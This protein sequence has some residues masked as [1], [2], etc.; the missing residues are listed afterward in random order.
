MTAAR[1]LLLAALSTSLGCATFNVQTEYDP[2]ANFAKYKVYDFVSSVPGQE[3]APA[4]R[5]P[6]VRNWVTSAI[7]RELAGKGCT[8][9]SAGVRPSFLVAY[10]AWGQQKVDVTTYGYSY[11]PGPYYYGGYGAY[12][13]GYPAGG[14]VEVHQYVE[15]TFVLD[16]VDT[17]TKLLVWRGT[18]AGSLA[19]TQATVNDV[20]DIVRAVV[21][22]WPPAK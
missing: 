9:A 12:G 5:N 11:M 14:G 17:E 6:V 7:Q 2:K 3:Q 21:A 1:P 15:G 16:F 10:H 18:A 22:T 19:G 4:I 13:Y 8:R 20:D